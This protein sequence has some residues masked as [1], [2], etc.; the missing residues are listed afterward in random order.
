[1][2][3][4]CDQSV[5]DEIE[6]AFRFQDAVIRSLILKR[7]EA[8]TDMSALAKANTD[9]D[10]AEKKSAPERTEDSTDKVESKNDSDASEEETVTAETSAPAEQ[11]KN[12]GS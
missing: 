1:M 2:N 3:V 8:I 12:N 11:E 5:R 4:E 9:E 6:T 10:A 7:D